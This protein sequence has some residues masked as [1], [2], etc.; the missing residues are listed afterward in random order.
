M[1]YDIF[2]VSFYE[3]LLQNNLNSVILTF[4]GDT[5]IDAK[6]V[7]KCIKRTRLDLQ[8]TQE[9]FGKVLGISKQSIC[10]W[11]KGRNL[12]DIINILKII[13]I[14]GKTFTKFFSENTIDNEPTETKV[15]LTP[16]EKEL[17]YKIRALTP[18]QY[19]A[20]ETIIK[21]M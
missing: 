14:S 13:D 1:F 7:A 3:I 10:S 5:M 6:F 2:N 15:Y 16:S 9:E 18:K 21:T 12:P 11:E 17:I 8:L 19:Q 4:G 20:I